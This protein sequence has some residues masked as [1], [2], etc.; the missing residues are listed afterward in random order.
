V[1]G[2]ANAGESWKELVDALPSVCCV[3]AA[4]VRAT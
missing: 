2:S 3:K 1:F 4:V